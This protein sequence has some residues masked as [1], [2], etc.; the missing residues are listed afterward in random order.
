VVWVEQPYR[1]E[2]PAGL[3]ESQVR[4][5]GRAGRA[6]AEALPGLAAEYLERWGLRRDG[7]VLHGAAALVLPV[8]RE[9]DGVPAALKLQFQE[10]DNAG[11]ATALRAWG[12]R[13]AVALLD[14]DDATGTLL[15]ERLDE[16][17]SLGRLPDTMEGVREIAELLAGLTAHPAPPGLRRLGDLTAAMLEDDVPGLLAGTA[18]PV[19]RGLLGR[20]AAAL[21]EVAGEAGDRL[22]HWDLHGENVLAPRRDS[23]RSDAWVAIDPKPLAGDPGFDLFPALRNRFAA[24]EVLPRFD[25]MTEVMGL[26]RRRAAAWTLARVVQ[27]SSWERADGRDRIPDTHVVIAETLLTLR[28]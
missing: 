9:G 13:R 1:V 28:T 25:L 10:E 16:R 4:W 6:W 8:L 19:Q 26:D 15:L 17:R 24:D 7:P 21:R 23:A 12:G 11:E 20:C 2:V 3:V 18:D 14:A 22:L 27:D 5:N